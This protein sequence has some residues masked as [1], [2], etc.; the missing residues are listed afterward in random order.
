MTRAKRDGLGKN[1]QAGRLGQRK[2]GREC[3]RNRDGGEVEVRRNS[4]RFSPVAEMRRRDPRPVAPRHE[5]DAGWEIRRFQGV[6]SGLQETAAV[7]LS[8]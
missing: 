1:L 8:I 3:G 6:R 2:K 7:F 5:R 4:A